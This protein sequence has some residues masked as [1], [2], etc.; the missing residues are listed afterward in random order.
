MTR[1][2][3][4]R[5]YGAL[6]AAA[7][8]G[9]GP[10]AAAHPENGRT[11]P[12]TARQ[13]KRA[14]GVPPNR[15]RPAERSTKAKPQERT[16][17]PKAA[18]PPARG[19]SR[20]QKSAPSAKPRSPRRTPVSRRSAA[21][22]QRATARSQRAR[23][24]SS[25]PPVNRKPARKKSQ[26][27]SKR[28]PVSKGLSLKA[29]GSTQH[30]ELDQ[31][32]KAVQHEL[33]SLQQ[34]VRGAL[35]KEPPK[36][37]PPPAPS[38]KERELEKE[39]AEVD[40][41]L[42]AIRQAVKRG[43]DP[44]A[45][46]DSVSNLERKRAALLA[47]LSAARPK[48]PPK[49]VV[50]AIPTRLHR[51]ETE[52]KLMRA[53]L[54]SQEQMFRRWLE[55]SGSSAPARPR[56]ALPKPTKGA[57]TRPT[58][59]QPKAEGSARTGAGLVHG[60][61][62]LAQ[63]NSAQLNES[64]P[65]DAESP[66]LKERQAQQPSPSSEAGPPASGREPAPSP[67]TASSPQPPQPAGVPSAPPAEEQPKQSSV[68]ET[69]SPNF[70][71]GLH[72]FLRGQV[73]INPDFD[74]SQGTD[75]TDV[76]QRVRLSL[77]AT[78]RN[79]TGYVELQDARA[80]GFEASTVSNEANTDLHQGYLQLSG[81]LGKNDYFL[82]AGRQEVNLGSKRMI[83]NL[84]WAPNARSF[85]TLRGQ[86]KTQRYTVDALAAILSPVASIS[87][88]DDSTDPPTQETIDSR[89]SQLLSLHFAAH[90]HPAFNGEL[91]L[92]KISQR[93]TAANPNL[94]REVFSPGARLLGKPLPGLQYE[95]E[96]YLQTGNVGERDH[97]AW[98]HATKLG[99]ELVGVNGK[100]GAFVRF[101]MASG[102]PC[103]PNADGE[104]NAEKSEEFFN[105][106]PLNHA[107]YGL[108]DLF[109]WRNLRDWEL[110][111][112][113]RP[114]ATTMLSVGYHY[115]QLQEPTGRWSS[116][117][118]ATIAAANPDNDD[119]DLGHEID[120]VFT[121]K[122]WPGVMIQPGYGVFIPTGAGAQVGDGDPQ[123]FGYTWLVMTL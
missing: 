120:L 115:F 58:G 26:V 29:R 18:K 73:R 71:L 3:T 63:L 64:G 114:S 28:K 27:S 32:I 76:L 112:Q 67:T 104:C 2:L 113:F 59:P 8:L 55:G 20:G 53:Q 95:L 61:A 11:A 123:H 52:L 75:P 88:T 14:D 44:S 101:S 98:A 118:G 82:R 16:P 66:P 89:G 9:H 13:A 49:P 97:V 17:R 117:G 107:Y 109:G 54:V 39:I 4:I 122:P 84:G 46:A 35:G 56:Q 41:K 1:L 57:P 10:S 43:L 93:P 45:V 70:K 85:D 90:F 37:P 121:Y 99:Y 78:F 47:E 25:S 72:T 23:G 12:G 7:L 86:L 110:G 36:P 22:R 19:A 34:R 108:V 21:Q 103:E 5:V 80:W 94:D 62:G 24:L 83:S 116:A 105:F 77:K 96:G 38:A 42:A 81:Q 48:P 6:M 100:P 74:G 79:L 31:R 33:D 92:L 40:G 68:E 87:V 51:L 30:T 102:E 69:E 50:V 119:R 111:A 91:H 15:K 65:A 106:F 60:G